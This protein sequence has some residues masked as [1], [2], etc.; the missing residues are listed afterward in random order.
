M[1]KDKK[2]YGY[3]KLHKT[4]RGYFHELT[5]PGKR[6]FERNLCTLEQAKFRKTKRGMIERTPEQISEY[7]SALWVK[8]LDELREEKKRTD[9]EIIAANITLRK[10]I[11]DYID[12]FLPYLS[13]SSF[14][15]QKTQLEWWK[16]YARSTKLAQ[17]NKA[18]I[19]TARR[20]LKKEKPTFSTVNRYIAAIRQVLTACVDEWFLLE[21]NPAFKIK[22]L[23][24]PEARTRNLSLDELERLLEACK[25]RP[26]LHLAVM[27]ALTTGARRMEIW[28]LE[29]HQIDFH[30]ARLIFP[31]PKTKN[32]KERIVPIGKT[33]KTFKM[34]QNYPTQLKTKL[35]FPSKINTNKPFDFKLPFSKAL[36]DAGIEKFTWHCLRHTFATYAGMSGNELQ[37][38]SKLLGHSGFDVTRKYMHLWTNNLE[39]AV[40]RMTEKFGL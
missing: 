30:E 2:D 14:K 11:D 15:T 39:E 8:K 10:C 17:V 18:W 13:D 32:G 6:P 28:G 16:I 36:E 40:D 23:P 27:L 5:P 22:N 37:Q 24:E 19:V 21:N 3:S 29:R 31:A 35:V 1:S 26:D 4:V 33:S 20:K 25:P 7:C 34:L 38:V 9:E 12:E